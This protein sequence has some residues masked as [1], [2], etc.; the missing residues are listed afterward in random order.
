MERYGSFITLES[1]IA[2]TNLFD[3][4]IRRKRFSEAGVLEEFLSHW[5]LRSLDSPPTVKWMIGLINNMHCHSS[6]MV[7]LTGVAI[8]R[9]LCV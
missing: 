1:L 4:L 7:L 8:R 6:E 3:H 9:L 2:V 5:H